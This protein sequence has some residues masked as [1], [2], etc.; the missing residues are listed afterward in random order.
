MLADR[1][2]ID[3]TVQKVSSKRRS[4]SFESPHVWLNLMSLYSDTLLTSPSLPWYL[5]PPPAHP[6]IICLRYAQRF[7][8]PL[9]PSSHVHFHSQFPGSAPSYLL[10]HEISRMPTY[11]YP[12]GTDS[13][14]SELAPSL[15]LI[16]FVRNKFQL[17]HR[18][19]VVKMKSTGNR[20]LK[21]WNPGWVRDVVITKWGK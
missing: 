21:F 8:R 3:L 9:C 12:Y 19:Q 13:K 6:S 15:P 11:V 18:F 1:D 5:L 14:T 10:L 2:P 20:G 4:Y 17:E 7:M 16:I